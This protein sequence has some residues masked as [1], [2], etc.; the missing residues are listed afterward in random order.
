MAKTFGPMH[1]DSVA[2]KF[3]GIT[4][5]GHGSQ[6]VV[7][8]SQTSL[9]RKPALQDPWSPDDEPNLQFWHRIPDKC[10][11]RAI[12]EQ[13]F[14]TSWGDKTSFGR[15]YVQAIDA[16]Q[17][18]HITTPNQW[19][20]RSYAQFDGVNDGMQSLIFTASIPQPAMLFLIMTEPEVLLVRR[21]V[22]ALNT[23][24][25]RGLRWDI[26]APD[27]YR[28]NLGAALLPGDYE[29]QSLKLWTLILNGASSAL[30]FNNGAHGPSGNIGAEAINQLSLAMSVTSLNWTKTKVFEDF[31]I[32]GAP[33]ELTMTRAFKYAQLRY[34]I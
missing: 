25:T 12:G 1:S 5:R 2:G 9:R 19:N 24:Y 27:G 18:E 29:S 17:P 28:L 6:K 11:F 7:S 33:S 30:R 3:G 22:L 31:C 15:N 10:G 20:N 4:F 32:S 16:N 26:T 14:I 34:G 21:Q 23:T 13:L 8:G